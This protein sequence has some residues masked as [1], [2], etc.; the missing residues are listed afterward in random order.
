MNYQNCSQ[1]PNLST[2]KEIESQETKQ[3][4]ESSYNSNSMGVKAASTKQ[5][6]TLSKATSKENCAQKTGML[7]I[8]CFLKEYLLIDVIDQRSKVDRREN[9]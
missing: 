1:N 8:Y 9:A 3:H 2:I 7:Q 5:A 6:H 4:E